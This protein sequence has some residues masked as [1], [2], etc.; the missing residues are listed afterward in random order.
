[1]RRSQR[2]LAWGLLAV[3]AL[4]AACSRAEGTVAPTRRATPTTVATDQI[5][6]PDAWIRSQHPVWHGAGYQLLN[7][8]RFGGPGLLA[9]GV[10]S[11]G[12][13][14][15]GALWV[16][17]DG[18]TWDRVDEVGFGGPGAQGFHDV[19]A[20]PA[21][22]VVVGF[23]SPAAD[24]D[25]AVWFSADGRSWDRVSSAAFR[26]VGQ[27]EIL[28]V[29]ATPTGFVAAGFAVTGEEADAAVWTSP[30]GHSWTRVEDPALSEPGTQRIYSLVVT[31]Q[32]LV[33]G[34]THYHPNQ[35]G[36]YNLDAR[37]WVS[38]DGSSWE[39][40]DDATFGGPGWQFI[41]TVVATPEGL[42]AAGGDILGQP[43]FHNDAAVWTSA[44][45]RTW[46]RVSDPALS[47][48]G[49]QH[50]SS[51]VLGPEGLI[52]VGYDTAPR[53]NRIPAVW[54]SRDGTRWVRVV[55]PG[56]TE[57]GHRWMN[58]VAADA[59][60]LVAVGTD[61]TRPVG[62]PAVWWFGPRM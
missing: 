29:V 45:G 48:I 57:P 47:G 17:K 53:G 1:M 32:G 58:A 13:D 18:K 2:S 52:A 20:G 15:D 42:V 28:T 16:S 3:L 31:P 14:A 37:I 54:S 25:A 4:S 51:L 6:A 23:D 55:D 30:D 12:P 41:S 43:G 11:S 22:I 50:I 7:S 62:D 46:A 33:A 27:E 59:K 61:G 21:G 39:V 49:A 5:A 38:A 40:V 19:A 44:D 26:Q 8:V 10:D 35:F 36:L 9:A 34:G 60:R 56:L 24:I